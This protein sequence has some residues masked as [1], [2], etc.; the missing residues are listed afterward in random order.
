MNKNLKKTMALALAFGT[1][2]TVGSVA[3]FKFLTIKAYA[4]DSNADKLN[5]IDLEDDDGDSV[6]IYKNSS[7][8]DEVDDGDLKVGD[9]YYAEVT[10]GSAVQVDSVD[11]A[12]DDK[13][14]IFVGS[15]AY[16][17]GDSI[18]I[19][20]ND[21]DTTTLKVRVYEDDYD[22]D[23]DYNSSDYN[24]YEVKVK[25]NGDDNDD[26]DDSNDEDTL[27]SLEL[28]DKNGDDI[29]LYSNSSYDDKVDSSEVNEGNTYYAKTSSNE[30]SVETSGP[31]DKYV[32]I[33]KSTDDSAKG[34]E[35]G[36]EISVSEDKTLT[37]RIYDEEPDDDVE[38]GDDD[39][40]IGEYKIKL[41]YTGADSSDSTS[42]TGTG[43][44]ALKP[45]TA[46]TVTTSSNVKSNQWVQ[47]NGNWLYNDTSGNPLKNQ[48]Y[49]DRSYGKW[50]YLGA[51]GTMV[52]NRWMAS[53]G[54][55]YYIGPD[56]AMQVNSWISSEGKW[57]YVGS[58]GA[59]VINTTINGYKIGSDG[60][61]IK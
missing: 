50:Y 24:E 9:T 44:T 36:D 6:D 37:V 33:F 35:T 54:K 21:G 43:A 49:Y 39:D 60:A 51:D 48:W 58:D 11:G 14:R 19:E 27:D 1:L 2:S 4:S 42:T 26:S 53:G 31:D 40:V 46:T 15:D 8:D 25:Y 38:Y 12:D 7:Y 47:V 55:W 29:D 16:E 61:W 28:Q 10:T 59:M 13:V 20:D 5:S 57:Y 3:N 52:V 34:V 32:R 45:E 17:V 56:G 22:E 41:E 30:V 23:K 18:P